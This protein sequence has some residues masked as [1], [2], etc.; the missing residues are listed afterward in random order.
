MGYWYLLNGAADNPLV[1][2][3]GTANQVRGLV[4]ISMLFW[5][6]L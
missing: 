2:Y 6:K 1:K 5:C 3:I 4:G